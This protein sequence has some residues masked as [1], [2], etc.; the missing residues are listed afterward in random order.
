MNK[1]LELKKSK[2]TALLFLAAAALIFGVT[3]FLPHSF[4][5][6]CL[7][8]VSEAAMV[9]AL[10]D[11][12]AVAAL[13][14]RVPILLIARHTNIIPNNKDRIADNFALF[15]Q[16]KFLDPASLVELI[17][18]MPPSPSWGAGWPH[19]PTT[20]SSA[21]TSCAWRPGCWTWLKTRALA[22]HLVSSQM[23]ACVG[24]RRDQST[25]TVALMACNKRS[26][27][28]HAGLA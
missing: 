1:E 25:T 5:V 23:K 8:A 11:W 2:R 27:Q 9:G 20:A 18:S 10:A 13:F 26:L 28:V 7:K 24:H 4:A 19:R 12:F 14:R 21:A 22:A 6:D 15:V 16:E 3:A 17:P